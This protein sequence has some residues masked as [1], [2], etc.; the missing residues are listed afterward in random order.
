MSAN[1]LEN[2]IKEL[3]FLLNY[4]EKVYSAYINN[5]K[6]FIYSKVL[7][8]V[9]ED[10]NK[11][12]KNNILLFSKEKHIDAIELIFHIDIWKNIWLD[13]FE[14]QK[15]QGRDIFTF[16]NKITFPNKSVDRLLS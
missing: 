9:N 13:E 3:K 12:V 7:F 2:L 8:G 10:I 5:N 4:A 6:E 11:L 15:P 16:P 14:K 1:A